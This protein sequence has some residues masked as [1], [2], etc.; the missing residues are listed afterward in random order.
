[1]GIKNDQL[2]FDTPICDSFVSSIKN[3]QQCYEFEPNTLLRKKLEGNK[4]KPFL[5]FLMDYNEDRQVTFD[6]DDNLALW[7][8]E[9]NRNRSETNGGLVSRRV[10]ESHIV[11]HANIYLN[12][13]GI[14][15]EN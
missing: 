11:P 9:I 13:V 4:L 6:D 5:A 8:K 3:G 12:T 10:A 2:K 15:N 1:M 14:S 7:N